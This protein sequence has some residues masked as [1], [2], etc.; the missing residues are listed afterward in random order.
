MKR[1]E[2]YLFIGA[3]V[4]VIVIGTAFVLGGLFNATNPSGNNSGETP[5]EVVKETITGEITKVSFTDS[6]AVITVEIATTSTKAY[7]VGSEQVY[8]I[9]SQS[10]KLYD[11]KSQT[12]PSHTAIVA[13]IQ[14]KIIFYH[15]EAGE[16]AVTAMIMNPEYET[17]K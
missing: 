7:S 4:G 3:A 11:A 14:T 13:N 9:D 17:S 6:E 12:H 2:L 8:T 16:L 1:S 10:I 5:V 15:N